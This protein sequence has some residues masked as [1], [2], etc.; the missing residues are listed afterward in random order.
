[1]GEDVGKLASF[2]ELPVVSPAS[3]PKA[4]LFDI[5]GTLV[6]SDHTIDPQV[7]RALMSLEKKGIEVGFATGR[8]LFGAREVL[9]QL[10]VNG[11]SMFFS[12]S[13]VCRP[14]SGEVLLEQ[15]MALTELGEIIE[16]GRRAGV[17]TELYTRSGYFV[18]EVT[19]LAV[20]HSE[21][22]GFLPKVVQFDSFIDQESILK[23]V[24]VGEDGS[25]T[26]T[27]FSII[28]ANPEV[29]CGVSYG[30]AHPGIVF[31][32]FTSAAA[33]RPNALRVIT[34]ALGVTVQQVAS[35]GDAVADL[36]FISRVGFGFA[37]GNATADVRE[38]A[39][40]VTSEVDEEGVLT[41]L[42]WMYGEAW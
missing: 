27:V 12:G 8:A 23:V 15:Q 42:R 17:Y 16:A 24:M 35:F 13:L 18:E 4:L 21:Y 41:A 1:M 7:L 30:A 32:N 14:Q 22:M 25:T 20:M 10:P 38:K 26:D 29:P 5:D 33:S 2:A 11:P 9:T 6:R 28:A 39:K 34:E 37:M 31:A 36:E 3:A 40:Y 19:P